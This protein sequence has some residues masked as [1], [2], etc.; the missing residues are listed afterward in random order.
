MLAEF[1]NR[2]EILA[3]EL[4]DLKNIVLNLQT[5]TM[6]VNKKLLEQSEIIPASNNDEPFASLGEQPKTDAENN[7]DT[8]NNITMTYSPTSVS[9]VDEN[10]MYFMDKN[11]GY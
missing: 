11:Y 5:Y 9:S 4:V 3:E 7:K 8:E 10:A 6:S 2:F 1:N